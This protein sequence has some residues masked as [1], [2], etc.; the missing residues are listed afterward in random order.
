MK[1]DRKSKDLYELRQSRDPQQKAR[2]KE[3]HGNDI[4]ERQVL[5][6][7]RDLSKRLCPNNG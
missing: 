6:L 5:V 7:R 2:E 3:K 4:N 1:I